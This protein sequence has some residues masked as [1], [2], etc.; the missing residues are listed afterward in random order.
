MLSI[1]RSWANTDLFAD[2]I[3]LSCA[4]LSKQEK[5]RCQA[6]RWDLLERN[7]ELWTSF[8]EMVR[9]TVDIPQDWKLSSLSTNTTWQGYSY[10]RKH[11]DYPYDDGRDINP[12]DA[13]LSIQTILSVGEATNTFGA[14]AA[15]RAGDVNSGT[16]IQPEIHNGDLIY[17]DGRLIH[18]AL[19]NVLG[20]RTF[21]LATFIH[22]S[23]DIMKMRV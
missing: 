23:I 21:V 8:V 3:A 16:L 11:R 4:K 6:R 1:I 15:I 12:A 18:S 13:T 20:S 7:R 19:P 17:Y 22:P 10:I 14:E 5:I 9:S 2:D